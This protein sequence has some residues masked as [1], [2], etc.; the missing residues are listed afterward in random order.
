M[1]A[2]CCRIRDRPALGL[3][4]YDAKD[5]DTAY[6]PIEPLLPPDGAPNVLIVLLD[7]VGFGA[8]SAFGGPCRTPSMA[9][10]S[11]TCSRGLP[12]TATMLAS[13]TLAATAS[14]RRRSFIGSIVVGTPRREVA[15][16]G[17]PAGFILCDRVGGA[18][19]AIHA[20]VRHL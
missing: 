15:V 7:D 9:K 2:R 5:P 18:R 16:D 12:W 1:P 6:L 10:L 17:G 3:T 20:V 14:T 4:T 19:E 11:S 13:L 8:S